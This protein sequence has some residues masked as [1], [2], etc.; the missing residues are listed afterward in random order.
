MM[1][2]LQLL[3]EDE[4][5][6]LGSRGPVYLGT[7]VSA[8]DEPEYVA[9]KVI[10]HGHTDEDLGHISHANLVEVYAKVC[11]S[12]RRLEVRELCEGGELFNLIAE[13]GALPLEQGLSVRLRCCAPFEA[14]SRAARRLLLRSALSCL[15]R[16]ACL[17]RSSLLAF[18]APARLRCHRSSMRSSLPSSTA[19]RAALL[20][21]SC[22]RTTC[23]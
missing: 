13:S 11:E 6:G 4:P 19:T 14:A 16:S 1:P 15:F 18:P 7:R 10:V 17:F 5:L 12:D 3:L 21:A 2:N 22:G 23:S 8:C 20:M 9:V